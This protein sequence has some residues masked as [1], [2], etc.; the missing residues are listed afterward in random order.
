MVSDH[1]SLRDQSDVII[2]FEMTRNVYLHTP[3]CTNA[4]NYFSESR[5]LKGKK[6]TS[7]TRKACSNCPTLALFCERTAD[8]ADQPAWRDYNGFETLKR[9]GSF[10][11]GDSDA[12]ELG[13]GE[14]DEDERDQNLFVFEWICGGGGRDRAKR[15]ASRRRMQRFMAGFGYVS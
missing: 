2:R 7:I 6:E 3:R 13:E 11:L 14:R 5:N 12:G 8:K 15:W 9:I 4:I 10:Q 1:R